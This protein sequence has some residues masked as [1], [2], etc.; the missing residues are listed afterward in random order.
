VFT[1]SF[2]RRVWQLS[3]NKRGDSNRLKFTCLATKRALRK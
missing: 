2:D 1:W 3:H